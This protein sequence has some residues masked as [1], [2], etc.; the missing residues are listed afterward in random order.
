MDNI[1]KQIVNAI[2]EFKKGILFE[3]FEKELDSI[4]K[5]V[6]KSIMNSNSQDELYSCKGTII[7][8]NN[9][10]RIFDVIY[11]NAQHRLS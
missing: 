5:R 3:E 10:R 9:M 2:E 4:E 6:V 8:L 11:T 7:A 1:D